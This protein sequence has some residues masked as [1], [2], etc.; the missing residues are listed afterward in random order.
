MAPMTSDQTPALAPGGRARL[1]RSA[2]TAHLERA[3]ALPPALLLFDRRRYDFDEELARSVG[4]V[5]AGAWRSARILGRAA[6]RTLEINEPSAVEGVRRSALALAWLRLGML[7]GRRRPTVVSYAIGNSDPFDEPVTGT[8]RRRLGRRVDHVLMRYVW[9]ECDRVAYGTQAAAD[10]YAAAFGR[11]RRPLDTTVLPA[12]PVACD[13]VD[14]AARRPARVVFLGDFSERKGFP[15]VAA[16]WPDVASRHAGAELVVLGKGRLE[17]LA[18]ELAAQPSVRLVVD[19]PRERIH[20]ELA[21]AGVLTLPSQRSGRWREQVG[22]PIVE[23]LAHGCVVVTTDETGLAD[24]LRAHG[25]TVLAAD[26]DASVLA[27]ALVATLAAARDP[28]DVRDDLPSCDGRLA[29]D[30][31]MFADPQ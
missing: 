9:Q 27:D 6:V 28:Q 2:R 29:A 15:L 7:V 24:W 26:A 21:S 13:C 20:A 1:Y 31:W 12:L 22:L 16:A 23:G 5:E 11:H 19:P 4:A 10:A 14:D 3:A 8:W 25:H 17:P 30:T 18:H